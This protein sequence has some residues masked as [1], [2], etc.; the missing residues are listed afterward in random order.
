MTKCFGIFQAEVIGVD[1]KAVDVPVVGGHAGIT[2]LPILSQVRIFSFTSLQH[3][4]HT[5]Y[6]GHLSHVHMR[7]LITR[8]LS[9]CLKC[10]VIF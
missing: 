8:I 5:I 10:T 6:C 1:P 4:L 9:Y 3:K 7:W 2:I